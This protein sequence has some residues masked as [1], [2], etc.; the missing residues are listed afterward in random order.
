MTGGGASTGGGGATTGA[1][2]GTTGVP[3]PGNTTAG[4]GVAFNGL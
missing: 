1:S 3:V 2:D 4:A